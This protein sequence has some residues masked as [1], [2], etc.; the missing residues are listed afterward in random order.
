MLFASGLVVCCALAASCARKNEETRLTVAL[1]PDTS[2]SG[3]TNVGDVNEL[4]VRLLSDQGAILATWEFPFDVN[5]GAEA[6]LGEVPHDG[7]GRFTAIGTGPVCGIAEQ[8]IFEGT[9]DVVEFDPDDD[10]RVVVPVSCA[11]V[12]ICTSPTAT[13]T[14]FATFSAA[15]RVLG[16]PDYVTCDGGG[17]GT[18]RTFREPDG[19]DIAADTLWVADRGFNRIAAF[20]PLAAITSGMQ[21][22]FA[23]G[24]GSIATV[25]SGTDDND[26][27]HPRSIAVLSDRLVV[28]DENNNRGQIT[29]PL[30]TG[31]GAIATI[32]L[33]QNDA[34][35]DAASN[36]GGA[37]GANTL[38]GP[39][40]VI[41]AGGYLYVA[42]GDNHRV[43]RYPV[44]ALAASRP[45]ADI[46]LGQADF[47]GNLPNRGAAAGADTLS[48]P[49]HL[50]TDGARLWIADAGNNRVVAY[51]LAGI[52]TGSSASLVLDAAGG[53]PF[54]D[55]RG[56][57]ANADRLVIAD[58]GN[59][60]VLVW[61]PLPVTAADSPSAVIGQMDVASVTPNAGGNAGNCP[62]MDSCANPTREP[63]AQTL[64]RPGAVLLRG[65]ELWVSDTCNA[66]VLRYSAPVR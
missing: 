38:D 1:E 41:Q 50:A 62:A 52:A 2:C 58:S 14:P 54:V 24:Q 23:V 55:P 5:A 35:N 34:D 21:L 60:R 53:V 63:T 39:A 15:D 10:Q 48:S 40:G 61:Q 66:R 27:D 32:A 64:S 16:Q 20:T 7:K 13:P 19:L 25:G 3:L 46:V 33:G 65:D 59:H 28:T 30:P 6:S 44:T 49:V 4:E 8:S 17:F 12:P 43:L 11:P 9:S 45:D 31:N 18:G 42:D 51:D 57:A 29:T 36:A 26:L 22:G 37:T 56:V 47:L